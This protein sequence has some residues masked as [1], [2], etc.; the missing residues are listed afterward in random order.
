MP[1]NLPDFVL[2]E[3]SDRN[4]PVSY[5]NAFLKPVG[6]FGKSLMTNSIKQMSSYVTRLS[7]VYSLQSNRAYITV[8]DHAFLDLKALE[9]LDRLEEWLS[10]QLA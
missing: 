9:S 1:F 3:A 4:L 7:K 8:G 6:G 5:A 2:V 10:S